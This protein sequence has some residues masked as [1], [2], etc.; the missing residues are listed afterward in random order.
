MKTKIDN[1]FNWSYDLQL[2]T[3]ID[4]K[5]II[6][7]MIELSSEIKDNYKFF[8]WLKDNYYDLI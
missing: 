3:G 6:N 4:K 1:Q 2:M 5:T 7:N 8:S